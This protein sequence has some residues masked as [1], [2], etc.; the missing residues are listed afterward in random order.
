MKLP[1]ES[2]MKKVYWVNR[3]FNRVEKL[4][5][6]THKKWLD[7]SVENYDSIYHQELTSLKNKVYW[8]MRVLVRYSSFLTYESLNQMSK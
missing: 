2:L 8:R 6:I 7:E 4:F 3:Y 5:D 1:E